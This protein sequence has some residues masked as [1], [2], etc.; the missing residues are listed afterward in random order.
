MNGVG[1]APRDLTLFPRYTGGLLVQDAN[2]DKRLDPAADP[3]VGGLIG[4]AGQAET[5]PVGADGKPVL[6]GSVLRHALFPAAAGGGKPNP[7][8][9]PIEFRAGDKPGLYR[10]TVEL[11]GETVTSS[12]LKPDSRSAGETLNPA[13]VISRPAAPINP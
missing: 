3:V 13:G 1:I 4:V 7:G 6:S 9:L 8:L 10:P 5:S 2:C 12:R 11:V